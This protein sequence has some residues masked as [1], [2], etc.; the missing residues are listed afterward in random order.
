MAPSTTSFL[1]FTLILYSTV[2]S[3]C[4]STSEPEQGRLVRSGSNVSSGSTPSDVEFPKAIGFV[5]DFAGTLKAEEVEK[6][7]SGL[8]ELQRRGKIDFAIAVVKST[9]ERD[10]FDYSLGMARE[11]KIGS[12]GGGILLV[13]A[14][15]DRKWWIQTDKQI[16]KEFSN[17]EI[18]VIGD[19]IAPHFHE[20][21]YND[22]LRACVKA[23]ADELAR[24]HNFDPINF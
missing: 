17:F 20:Q 24:K 10:I 3:G 1:L 7:E 9:G 8:R 13:V 11:W 2:I 5:N 19:T 14:I 4:G 23:F 15:E 6:L 18:K 16:E 12:E 21:R 22:G